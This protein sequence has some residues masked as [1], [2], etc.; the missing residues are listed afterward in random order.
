MDGV[1]AAA[2][3]FDGEGGGNLGVAFLELAAGALVVAW[4][5]VE[6]EAMIDVGER[7]R[8]EPAEADFA[9]KAGDG[10][11]LDD[12]VVADVGGRSVLDDTRGEQA[13]V[14]VSP[15][16]TRFQGRDEVDVVALQ[17]CGSPFDVFRGRV[18]PEELQEVDCGLRFLA[19]EV[20]DREAA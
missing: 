1:G 5:D 3:L 7:E 20:V 12:L 19:R 4:L 14:D 6:R 17:L 8:D 10:Q 9:R 11:D 18:F 2:A 13:L 15:V 16:V